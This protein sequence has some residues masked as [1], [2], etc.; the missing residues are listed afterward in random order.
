MGY[1]H[2]SY[3]TCGIICCAFYRGKLKWIMAFVDLPT[4]GTDNCTQ[5]ILDL[6][7]DTQWPIEVAREH[8]ELLTTLIQFQWPSSHLVFALWHFG[9]PATSLH[10]WPSFF[11][12]NQHLLLVSSKNTPTADHYLITLW[13]SLYNHCSHLATTAKKPHKIE[14]RGW[15]T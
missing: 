8:T 2:Q 12:I 10:L 3:S 1:K 4:H 13:H 6:Q 9:R 11:G 7:L 15:S 5:V 14:V